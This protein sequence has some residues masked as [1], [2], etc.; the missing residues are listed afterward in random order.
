MNP[1]MKFILSLLVTLFCLVGIYLGVAEV[2]NSD[3]WTWGKRATPPQIWI[4]M[5]TGPCLYALPWSGG[6]TFVYLLR[7]FYPK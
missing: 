6:W 3:L 5:F 1:M 2:Q 4:F 7:L